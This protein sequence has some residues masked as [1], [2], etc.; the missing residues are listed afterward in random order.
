MPVNKNLNHWTI[1]VVDIRKRKLLY[2]DSMRQ[3]RG[4]PALDSDEKESLDVL[5]AWVVR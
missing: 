1:M 2:L 3:D 5:L 4:L